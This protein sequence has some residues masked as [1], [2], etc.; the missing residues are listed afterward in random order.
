[1]T[2]V[3]WLV[4]PTTKLVK[5]NSKRA[6]FDFVKICKASVVPLNFWKNIEKVKTAYLNIVIIF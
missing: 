6:L 5:I 4:F 1:M 3:K 2:E